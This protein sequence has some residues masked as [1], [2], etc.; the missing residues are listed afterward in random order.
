M[1]N[2]ADIKKVAETLASM[3]QYELALSDFYK[4]CADI[5]TED[6]AFW[7]NLAHAE[8]RHAENMQ[9]MLEII[10]KKQEKFDLGRSFNPIALNTAIAGLKDNASRL[11]A[12][13]FSL[14]KVLFLSRDIEQSILE[15]HYAEI[16]KTADAEY[17][18]LVKEILYQTYEH[19]KIIQEKIEK[20]KAT[21]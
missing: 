9:K 3:M 8:V 12:R 13:M 15:S 4:H 1:I 6:Q 11:T 7:H 17:Q 16:V 19:R 18:A 5:W 14:E 2:I 20:I 21:A 10:T